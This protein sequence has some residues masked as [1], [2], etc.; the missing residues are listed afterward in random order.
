MDHHGFLPSVDILNLFS[1][2]IICQLKLAQVA[3][4]VELMAEWA[5]LVGMST[6]EQ[7]LW[8]YSLMARVEKP[9][10]PDTCR[11]GIGVTCL[12]I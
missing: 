9:L 7:G 5:E 2:Q 8:I 4:L 1:Q 10:D 12:E 3:S 11:F 6:P